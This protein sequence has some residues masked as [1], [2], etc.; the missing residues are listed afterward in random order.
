V[1]P[2]DTRETMA[3]DRWQRVQD[4]LADAIDCPPSER[5]A[6]LDARC[7]GDAALRDE[8]ESLLVAHDGAGLVDQ[9]APLVKPPHAWIPQIEAIEWTG[10]RVGRYLVQ[11]L[12]GAGGMGVVYKAVDDRL[13]RQ[14]ALKFLPSHL[15]ADQIAK[16]R[17]VTEARAAAALDHPN[18]CTIYEIGETDDGQL[19]IAMPLY[20]GETLH[21]R[22]HRGRLSFQDAL[23][24]ALQVARGLG[25]AHE[26][27]IVH[28][29][30]KPANIVL[31][32]D[33]TA[34]VLDFGIAQI[35]DRA[36][37]DPQ[38][39]IGTV[40]YMSPEQASG[41][42]VDARSDVWSLAVVIHEMVAGV[43]PFGDGDAPDAVQAI[44][45]DEPRLTATSY[46][47]V[48][49]GIDRVLR[50]ALAKAPEQRYAS[51]SVL[52]AE[53]MALAAITDDGISGQP[54]GIADDPSR[55]STTERRRAAVLVT[56]V[57]DYSSLVDQMTPTEAHRLIGL[58]RDTAVDVAREFGGLVN[59]AIGEEIVSL[60]GVPVAHDDD[61]LRAVR[62]ALELHARVRALSV[63][64]S[65]ASA[66]L[67][68]QSGLHVGAVVARR[69][70]EGPRRYEVAGAPA[71]LAAR[72]A[73]VAPRDAVLVSPEA[74][75]LIGPYMQ[76]AR[77]P[78][79]VLDSQVGPVAP[80]Q[81]LGE[82][83]IAT[84]LEASTRA[85]LTPYV[86]RQSELSLLL[87]QVTTAANAGAVLAV[88]GEAGAGKSRLL[89]E[90]HERLRTTTDVR[91]LRARCHAYGDSV[92]YGVF[93]QILCAVLDLR[94]PL[95]N[96]DAVIARIRAVD[97]SL[98]PFLP[99]FLHL[100]SVSSERHALPKHLHGEHLQSA[101]L[102]AL[103][104]MVSTLTRR[105]PVGIL[106][107]DWHWADTGSRAAFL[108]VAELV[109]SCP[110]VLI[111]T[112]RVEHGDDREWPARATRLHLARLGFADSVAIMQAVLGVRKVSDALAR[113]IY[114]RAG[115]NPFFIE[116]LCAALL[117]RRA[118]T[119]S[120]EEAGAESGDST[121][122]LP[123]TVQGVIRARLD[124]LEVHALET[125]RVASV[126]GWDFDHALLAEVAPANVDLGPA[127]AALETAGLIQQTA[128]A[129]TISY[130]FTHALTQEVCYDTLVGHQRKTLHG[131]IGRALASAHARRIDD[132]AALLAYHFGRA[133]EWSA[134]IRFGRRAAERAIAL[135]QFADALITLD[136]VLEW[137]SRLQGDE[138]GDLVA[139]VL[140]QQ[141]RVCETLGLRARQ[142]QIIDSLITRLA[143]A[144][145]S[146]RL[147]E[148]YLRQGDLSTLLKR[149]DE[150]DRALGTAIRI[151]HEHGDAT[152]LR[153]GLRSLGLL[154]WHE[155][156]HAEAMDIT[157]RVLAI[158]RE[159]DDEDAVAVDLT[160]LGSI[161][162]AMGDYAGA[163]T[164]LEAA[165]ALPVI[166]RDP[167]K[168]LY[169]RH[170]LANV[171]RAM[172]D[173]DRA[174]EC[175]QQNDD[176]AREHLLP[177][178]RSFHLT[179]IAH[180][181]M[182]Q[183]RI[184]AALETYR[185]AVDLS[186]RAR[187]AD[188]LVQ[189]LR[190]LGNALL[191]LGRYDEALPYL[192]EATQLFAQL[193]DHV[194]E[195][196]MW[197]GVAQIL[198]RRSPEAAADAWN[199][200]LALQRQRG[201]ARGELMAREGV[202]RA[203]R[204]TRADE[205]IAA[206][207]SA[208]ALSTTIGARA[209]EAALR[210]VLGNL[211]WE[212]GRY[213]EALR[214]YESALALVRDHGTRADEVAILNSLGVCLTKL[215]RRDEARTVLEQSLARS[216]ETGARQL[217]AHALAALGQVSLGAQDLDAAAYYFDQSRA[218]RH[219][220]GDRAGEGWMY[221]RTAAIQQLRGHGAAARS[222]IDL[223]RSA[224]AETQDLALTDACAAAARE[225]GHA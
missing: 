99:L 193:E 175:L 50:R 110:L 148:V 14:A 150:A 91:V 77:C 132:G 151:G 176:A 165:L 208:L 32:S 178:Q 167:K 34:K 126:I 22:L 25:R 222:A 183:G 156:R 12:L 168:V 85:G 61:D 174:L 157:Q 186:R 80:W 201:D 45:T 197:T 82:S 87:S 128:V 62:A 141:E 97:P 182:Q 72:L 118:L 169:T 48:P 39:L 19:F 23:P 101:L 89:Y 46:P 8:V 161:L 42:P 192:Q 95:G 155:G 125:I 108:R 185:A 203:L 211:H 202:A 129:P 29:D 30:V 188:G 44:L 109:G 26:S 106:V 6:L 116:Q 1:T 190:M 124:N 177:I 189:S 163:R 145:A 219:A 2:P 158:D 65:P 68:I 64:T 166:R 31:L 127:L 152:L 200:V 138:P 4:L 198:E 35:R 78:P 27:G 199:T 205:A 181:Q 103:A 13:G 88:V 171:H 28:R 160:N 210:N 10:R 204:T 184:D 69:L 58:L 86:G 59:Q 53:L 133:E 57:S 162:R 172:G 20:E 114:D 144:G 179:S 90:L 81:V 212:R 37:A 9:L 224:A 122:S 107:E 194:S 143:A 51:M 209:R 119:I 220:T 94:A 135:S 43:R 17:F 225:T 104:T 63:V 142:Q 66:T 121:L 24:I 60:F 123:D 140:L 112:S 149:F 213:A 98:E 134:A 76:T 153:S 33:G 146:P 173:L 218:V 11:E 55:V 111:L 136:H 75:R 139:D 130:R 170:N 92:P 216:R 52:A 159:C 71:T 3:P 102:D 54:F 164:H 215:G 113:H 221:L 137:V 223:A 16:S 187:H 115:G 214:F 147:A 96:A 36:F 56:V 74:Q 38:T 105:G 93:V 49:A 196:E 5:A 67:S 120:A 180:I 117:E 217:E 21:A 207:E 206:Y 70:H 47:D 7:G 84:R 41:G 154:R 195:A 79:V 18:V 83:G 73:A 191:G 15:S 40:A 131:V 100:L